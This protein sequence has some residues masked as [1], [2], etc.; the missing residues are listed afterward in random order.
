MAIVRAGCS[1]MLYNANSAAKDGKLT[2]MIF[3]SPWS[4]SAMKL[5]LQIFEPEIRSPELCEIRSCPFQRANIIMPD[6]EPPP[7]TATI[8]E[9]LADTGLLLDFIADKVCPRCCSEHPLS[10]LEALRA[11]QAKIEHRW[12]EVLARQAARASTLRD[13]G[14]PAPAGS[15]TRRNEI[16]EKILDSWE[17][18]S[19]GLRDSM[20]DPFAF[21]FF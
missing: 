2:R 8:T 21:F 12:K 1:I 4:L 14:A 3:P 11:R 6:P 16:L 17:R 15:G 20:I 10:Q 9:N 7:T 5:F 13:D 18:Y 19:A